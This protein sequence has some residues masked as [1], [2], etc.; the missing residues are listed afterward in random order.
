M[1]VGSKIHPPAH[2]PPR[3]IISDQQFSETTSNLFQK[4]SIP[5]C[6]PVPFKAAF[7]S[8]ALGIQRPHRGPGRQLP[9]LQSPQ[10]QGITEPL[11]GGS[12]VPSV[13]PDH[14]VF[15]H[16]QGILGWAEEQS[17]GGKLRHKRTDSGLAGSQSS[18]LYPLPL[19]FKPSGAG[20]RTGW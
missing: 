19:T 3:G 13:F 10:P 9:G 12:S 14:R 7:K 16:R 2:G 8:K 18:L 1:G 4:A 6:S 5:T 17:N 11:E 15:F 20:G